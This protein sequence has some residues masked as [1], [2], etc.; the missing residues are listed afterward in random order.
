L[1]LLDDSSLELLDDSSLELL[2]DSELELLDDSE[3]EDELDLDEELLLASLLED[4][5]VELLPLVELLS[6]ELLEELD[7]DEELLDSL[8]LLEELNF[9]EELL[10]P[11][12]LLETVVDEPEVLDPSDVDE[13]EVLDPSDVDEPEVLDPSDVDEPDVELVG[14]EGKVPACENTNPLDCNTSFENEGSDGSFCTFFLNFVPP[15]LYPSKV[16][17]HLHSGGLLGPQSKYMVTLSQ[18]LS[19]GQVLQQSAKHC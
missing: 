6:S 19:G 9:D 13:P 12:E 2:D 5:S 15:K 7:F 17:S 1:L 3:L 10:D 16:Q 4:P 11:L 18:Q 14:T 8:E